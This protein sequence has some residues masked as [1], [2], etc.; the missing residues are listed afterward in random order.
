MMTHFVVATPGPSMIKY[1]GTVSFWT[2]PKG[3]AKRGA[4]FLEALGGF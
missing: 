4:G 2:R 3:A 1:F